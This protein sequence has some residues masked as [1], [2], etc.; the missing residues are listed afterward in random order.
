MN[1]DKKISTNKQRK[2]EAVEVLKAKLQKAKAFFLTDYRGLTHKQLESLRKSLK[3]VEA[4][5]LV[6]KNRLFN[7]ALK[8]EEVKLV[9]EVKNK[10]AEA[11]NNPTAT[12]LALG[13]EI[14]AIKTLATFVTANQIPKIKLGVFSGGLASETDFQKLATLPT[15]NVLLAT[16]VNRLQSP[17]YGLH[18]GLNWNLQ[19]FV[20]VLENVKN[21]KEV[22]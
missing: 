1:K 19:K 16:L 9:T 17:I 12:L 5:Y 15:R 22:R 14:A 13:D 2:M 11:L 8:S 3:K 18:R 21:K 10:L 20:T 7:L 6:A 4:E